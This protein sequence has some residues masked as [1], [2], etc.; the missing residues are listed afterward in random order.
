M[1]S[2]RFPGAVGMPSWGAAG[3]PAGG[4]TLRVSGRLGC[5]RS[6]GTPRV[7]VTGDRQGQRPRGRPRRFKRNSRPRAA[8]APLCSAGRGGESAR[9]SDAWKHRG[10]H[11]ALTLRS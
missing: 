9:V 2:L 3:S 7:P 5:L 8:R 10:G 4:A 6:Q 11:L 1:S